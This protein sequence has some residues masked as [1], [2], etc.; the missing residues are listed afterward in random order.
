[1]I[2]RGNLVRRSKVAYF[3]DVCQADVCQADVCQA[4]VCQ[5]PFLVLGIGSAFL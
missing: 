2:F 4:D 5:G 1:M 3:F